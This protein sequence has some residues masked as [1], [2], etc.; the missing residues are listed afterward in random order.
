MLWVPPGFQSLFC[1]FPFGALARFWVIIAENVSSPY[2][3]ADTRLYTLPCRL[4]GRSVHPSVRPSATFLNSE[5]F[6]QYC[7][8]PTVRDWIAV[9]PALFWSYSLFSFQ[10]FGLVGRS[11]LRL[12]NIW[13]LSRSSKVCNGPCLTTPAGQDLF[14]LFVST[15]YHPFRYHG[16]T[17][18]M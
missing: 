10:P 11:A 7:S 8:C 2:L 13:S 18:C 17:E 9:Y 14:Q 6:L 15:L 5:R 16:I 1:C 3:V 12:P 4:V